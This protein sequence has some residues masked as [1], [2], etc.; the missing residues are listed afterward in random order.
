MKNNLQN[1]SVAEVYVFRGK[2]YVGW[3]CFT[4]KKISVGSGKDADLVLNDPDIW[5][6]QAFLYFYFEDDKIVVSDQTVGHGVRVNGLAVDT[7]ILGQLD[8][9]SIGPYNLKIKLHVSKSFAQKG[10]DEQ[11]R[12]MAG[13]I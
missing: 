11:D 7:C 2:D 8:S 5:E 12:K 4:K 6:I 9:I 3:D 13:E 10:D 1:I